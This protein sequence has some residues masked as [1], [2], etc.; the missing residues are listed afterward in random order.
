MTSNFADRLQK[1]I[2]QKGSPVCV[3]LDPRYERLPE[4]FRAKEDA[5]DQAKLEAVSTYCHEL[6]DVIAE[7]IP[8]VKPQVAC[9]EIFRGEGLKLYFDLVKR[10]KELGL[11]VIGDIKRGDI[12]TSAQA[13]A[14]GHLSGPSAPD[15]VTVNG[16]FG[17][18][19]LAPFIDIARE[20]GKGLFV[21]VRTSNPS[22]ITV[23]DFVDAG[24]NKFYE[25]MAR[26][27]A[28]LGEADGLVGQSGLSCVGAVVGATYPDEARQLRT[29]MDKQIFLVPGY[30]A[31]GGTA[32]DC[33]ASFRPDGTGAIVNASRSV[34]YAHAKAPEL[35]WKQAV[36]NAAVAFRDDL[37]SIF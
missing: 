27:V 24:G 21:L 30:G 9:F 14:L 28:N 12:G 2:D 7:T 10:A 18:D 33:K 3:G 15:A 11:V 29:I 34:I 19:G 35:D 26:N 22:A 23:Q 31:Q 32:A 20:E 37:S 13:Y 17:I 4:A 16:Y 25:H 8:A 1:A 6:L 5:D 36:H